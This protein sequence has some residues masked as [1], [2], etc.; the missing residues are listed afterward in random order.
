MAGRIGRW[1]G[2]ILGRPARA[3]T[4][5]ESGLGPL[6]ESRARTFLERAGF[7]IVASNYRCPMGE[8]DLVAG[9]G[10]VLVFVEVKARRLESHGTPPPE[11]AVNRAKQKKIGR[12]ARYFIRA[13]KL[14]PPRVRFDVIAIDWP[15]DGEPAIRHFKAA[16]RPG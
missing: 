14:A 4:A 2:R 5:G 12:C 3:A 6:S 9:D 15:A 16:F 8:I 11:R 13:R 1:F 7:S 10:D